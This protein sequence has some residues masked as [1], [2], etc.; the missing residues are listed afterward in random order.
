MRT[1]SGA[2]VGPG[3]LLLL[4]LFV[5]M[6]V[7]FWD[8]PVLWP[9]KLLVVMMHE[10]GHALAALLVGGSVD[11]VVITAGE[12]GE[13][14]SR[15]PPSVPGQIL[16]FSAGYLGSTLAAALLL[17]CTLRF[18]M[19]RSVL[20]LAC[21]WLVAMGAMYAGDGFT[22]AFCVAT[23]LAL[24]LAARLLPD[25]AVEV[26]NLFLAAFSGLYALIDLRD[27]LWDSAVRT[28]SDAA[29]LANL[30]WVPAL[31]WAVLWTLASV[32]LL[33]AF[34]LWSVR[35]GRSPDLPLASR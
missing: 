7:A 21:G 12:A 32:L 15:L 2:H 30:T 14:L 16:V 4:L 34:V 13:C 24:A 28:Q 20:V 29:L 5:G 11:R 6:G 33:T 3:R 18:R 19:R 25:G 22:L 23:A 1:T 31:A 35:G 10:S 9:L 8:S 26:L 27:D 17:V